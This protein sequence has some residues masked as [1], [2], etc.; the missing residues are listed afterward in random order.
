MGIEFK[1]FRKKKEKQEAEKELLS[2]LKIYLK[3]SHMRISELFE[4]LKDLEESSLFD[5]HTAEE[6]LEKEESWF[7]EEKNQLMS[8]CYYT[9]VLFAVMKR[10]RES[11]PFLKLKAKD[12]IKLLDLI[13]N[14]MKDYMKYFKIHYS[15]QSNIGEMVYEEQQKAVLPYKEFCGIIKEEKEL[16]K[17]ESLLECYLHINKENAKKVGMLLKDMESLKEFLDMTVPEEEIN[18]KQ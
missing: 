6:L 8:V 15:M 4:K 16:Q 2:L 18:A 17:Y 11:S 5:I 12:D 14:I 9:A 1:F 13:N 10:V 3:E 7:D